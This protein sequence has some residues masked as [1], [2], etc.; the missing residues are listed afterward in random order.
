LQKEYHF[1]GYLLY[2]MLLL[3]GL[4]G[5]GVGVLMPWRQIPMNLLSFLPLPLLLK[6]LVSIRILPG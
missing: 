6:G 5:M 3:G 1:I 4:A 2:L